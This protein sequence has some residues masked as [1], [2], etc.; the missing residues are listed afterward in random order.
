MCMTVFLGFTSD[1]IEIQIANLPARCHPKLIFFVDGLEARNSARRLMR[2]LAKSVSRCA[3][4]VMI[5]KLWAS[6]PP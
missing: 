5:A 4:S 6:A 2:K 1:L 3:A